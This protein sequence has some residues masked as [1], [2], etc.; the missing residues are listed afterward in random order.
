M[1]NRSQTRSKSSVRDSDRNSSSLVALAIA[2]GLLFMGAGY[3]ATMRPEVEDAQVNI[4]NE[5]IS[6]IG[7]DGVPRPAEPDHLDNP[8]QPFPK[9]M[10]DDGSSH[11]CSGMSS[12]AMHV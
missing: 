8:I 12:G 7:P 6:P 5:V 9:A 10:C 11:S 4:V 3:G 2:L 1:K